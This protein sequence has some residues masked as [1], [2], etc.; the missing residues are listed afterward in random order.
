MKKSQKCFAVNGKDGKFSNYFIGVRNGAS[1]NQD[2][3]REGY[4][5]VVAAR[6]ADAKFF[7][8]NDL[9]KGLEG[10]IEKLKGIIFHKE[11]G[12]IFEKVERI[13]QIAT[14]LNQ[15]FNMN[16]DEN[17]LVKTIMFAKAD[18]VS[19]MVFEYPELQGI[20][21]R[22]Y[23]K[24]LGISDDISQAIEQHYWPLS[25]GGK[26]P[27][28]KIAFLISLADKID[29]LAA[30]FSIGLEPSGSADPYGLRRAGI[31]FIKMATENL[32]Q[33]DLARA[34]DK[35]FDYLPE[36]VKN[37]PKFKQASE[38]LAMFF[39]QRIENLLE[40]EGYASDDVKAVV[41]ASKIKRLSGLGTLRPKL[42]SLKKA[43][44][45]GDFASIAAVFK[46][47]NNILSQAKKQNIEI[48]ENINEPLLQD[49]AEIAL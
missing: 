34:M 1:K 11:I 4:E 3:V 22:I 36:S 5:K 23:A 42:D 33:E 21:G 30:N 15:E 29:T 45:K 16:I 14:F 17:D 12:A 48:A 46:R 32:P 7:Y 35:A 26:I 44:Q 2:T 9:R 25:A 43:K 47:I 8:H 37:N 27:D 6:L 10:N 41:S 31:S 24:K 40:S 13:K 19:E 28:N 49:E 39:W 20:M 38:R 18:L